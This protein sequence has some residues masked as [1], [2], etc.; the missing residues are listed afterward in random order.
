VV[1]GA[2]QRIS[3]LAALK[4]VTIDAAYAYFEEDRKG[5]IAPGKFADLVILSDNPLTV[6]PMAIRD[7]RVLETIKEGRTIYAAAGRE[8]GVR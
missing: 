6:D 3:P 7:I 1:V 2:E 4:A 5:S 8:T